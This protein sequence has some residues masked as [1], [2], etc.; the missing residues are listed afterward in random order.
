MNILLSCSAGITTTMLAQ[1][2]EKDARAQGKDFTVWAVDEIEIVNEVQ[3]K[4][5]NLILLGPQIKFKLKAIRKKLAG[6]DVP[7]EVLNSVDFAMGNTGN[8]IK[9]IEKKVGE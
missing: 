2:I 4:D 8:I 5:I 3:S 9:Y 6:Y 1:D 7:V